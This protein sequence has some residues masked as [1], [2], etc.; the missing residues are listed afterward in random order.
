MFSYLFTSG[1]TDQGK[2]QAIDPIDAK[3]HLCW[4]PRYGPSANNRERGN[5]PQKGVEA[6]LLLQLMGEATL[7]SLLKAITF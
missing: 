2:R 6:A 7:A 3:V 1:E 4:P 5:L